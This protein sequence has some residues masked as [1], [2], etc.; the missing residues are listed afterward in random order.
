VDVEARVDELFEVPIEDF[1]RARN[2]LV[3]ELTAAGD[4]P[5][6]ARVKALKKPTTTV[7]AI[8]QLAH[9]HGP[10]LEDLVRIHER[11]ASVSGAGDLKG[12]ADDR[13]K[14]VRRLTDLA[15]EILAGA[16]HS[17]SSSQTQ[18][19]SQSL[20][21]AA[22]GQEL[23]ALRW[24]RL[25]GDIEGPGF[26]SMSGFAEAAESPVYEKID[27]RAQ[28]RMAKLVRTA[29]ESEAEAA[30][31]ESAA[32]KARDEAER[33]TTAATKAR[34]KADDARRKADEAAAQA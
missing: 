2:E 27:K 32:D 15:A 5:A 34:R 8:N 19:I 23:D 1:T 6:A 22:S 24:G 29:A 16:G 9:R 31:L 14:V 20:L 10:E 30:R 13:R 4:K 25:T 12:A 3:K 21:A 11:M 18:R 28:E 7:W 33:L 17:A 26:D